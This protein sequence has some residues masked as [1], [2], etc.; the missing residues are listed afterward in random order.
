M[1]V[2]FCFAAAADSAS[3]DERARS[4]ESGCTMP[5]FAV[6]AAVALSMAKLIEWNADPVTNDRPLRR[7]VYA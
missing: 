2:A 4:K 5:K 3:S 6:P 7:R 1:P